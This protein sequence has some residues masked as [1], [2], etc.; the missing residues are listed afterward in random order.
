MSDTSLLTGEK[1]VEALLYNSAEPTLAVYD[2]GIET[3]MRGR[4]GE[5]DHRVHKAV[6]FPV[7]DTGQRTH[8][9]ITDADQLIIRNPTIGR[10]LAN[11]DWSN[12]RHRGLRSIGLLPYFIGEKNIKQQVDTCDV[13]AADRASVAE[14]ITM[15]ISD[16]LEHERQMPHIFFIGREAIIAAQRAFGLASE[17]D[18]PKAMPYYEFDYLLA[19][20]DE[21]FMSLTVLSALALEDIEL[22]IPDEH[23]LRVLLNLSNFYSQRAV[24]DADE[25]DTLIQNNY[26]DDSEHPPH[27][28]DRL[29]DAIWDRN[30]LRGLIHFSPGHSW[31]IQ[32]IMW[33]YDIGVEELVETVQRQWYA[34]QGWREID[35][36]PAPELIPELFYVPPNPSRED[37]FLASR[38]PDQLT[39]YNRIIRKTVG[40]T[41]N[42]DSLLDAPKF[43]IP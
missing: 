14:E 10:E 41:L 18:K 11:R 9:A 37:D 35:I 13:I 4:P 28:V 23:R 40:A 7:V 19:R 30:P 20:E 22:W 26:E 43:N 29:M 38:T 1:A 16:A 34:I 15:E 6:S 17:A 2:F 8:F 31:V 39:F 42:L 5:D 21:D 27:S 33:A 36:K 3:S 12:R 24:I 25:M 32:K